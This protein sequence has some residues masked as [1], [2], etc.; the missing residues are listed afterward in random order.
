MKDMKVLD[1]FRKNDSVYNRYA[2]ITMDSK[3]LSQYYYGAG[4][5]DTVMF[6][7]AYEDGYAI[8]MDACSPKLK[9]LGVKYFVF[10]YAPKNEEVRCMIKLKETAGLFIYKRKDE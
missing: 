7:Q 2:W 4:W 3:Q 10:D 1:P 9:Q 6:R 5:N 8:Y